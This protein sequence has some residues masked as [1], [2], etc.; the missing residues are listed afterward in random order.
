VQ[1]GE[2]H[3]HTHTGTDT[4]PAVQGGICEGRNIPSDSTGAGQNSQK[5]S[6]KSLVKVTCLVYQSYIYHTTSYIIYIY[7]SLISTTQRQLYQSYI[8]YATSIISVLYL[9]RNVNYIYYATSIISVLY[10]LRN[11]NYIS[12]ISTTQRPLYLISTTQRHQRAEHVL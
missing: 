6:Q 1:R 9:L 3:T 11:V 7:I 5:K 8:Y 12:L 4:S 2:T 10:L